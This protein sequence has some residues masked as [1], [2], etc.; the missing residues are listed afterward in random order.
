[1]S[2]KTYVTDVLAALAQRNG[3]EIKSR[4]YDVLYGERT[5]NEAETALNKFYSDFRGG[6]T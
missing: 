1:L 2:Y 4:W 6:D 5:E 3:I